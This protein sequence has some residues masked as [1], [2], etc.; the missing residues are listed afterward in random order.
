M[1]TPEDVELLVNDDSLTDVEKLDRLYIEFRSSLC[2]RYHT[3]AA[4]IKFHIQTEGKIQEIG[5]G[6]IQT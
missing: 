6:D 4:K 3:F 1:T 2:Q 5:H